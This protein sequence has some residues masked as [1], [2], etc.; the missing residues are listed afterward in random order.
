MITFMNKPF[1]SPSDLLSGGSAV[2]LGALACHAEDRHIDTAAVRDELRR[3]A[4]ESP[5]LADHAF[6]LGRMAGEIACV[7]KR[8]GAL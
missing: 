6:D 7:W 4:T 3:L 5:E 2:A 1:G 8:T